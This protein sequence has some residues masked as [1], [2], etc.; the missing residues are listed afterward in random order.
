MNYVNYDKIA[1]PHFYVF[2]KMF[3]IYFYI[4]E[5]CL[6]IHQLNIIEIIK[7]NYK[8]KKLVK[9]IKAFL[10]KKK[11]KS[12]KMVVNDTKIF[13]KIKSKSLFSIEKNIIK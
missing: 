11:K 4:Y 9:D 1:L 3:I 13:Q 7:K 6:K 10:K 5:K 8:I 12:N 2:K